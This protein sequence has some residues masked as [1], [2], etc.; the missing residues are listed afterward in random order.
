MGARNLR[1]AD[2]RT[3]SIGFA[4]V[5]VSNPFFS[6]ILRGLEEV[7]RQH[8]YLVLS[9]SSDGDPARQDQLIETFIARRVD[10]LVVVP[11]SEELGPISSEI[12]RGMPVVFVDCEPNAHLS[13]LVR[14]DHLGGTVAITE[15]LIAHGHRR[16]AFLGDDPR[17]FSAT[18]RLEGFRKAVASAGLVTPDEWVLTGHFTPNEWCGRICEWMESLQERP[19]A[20][21]AAQNFVTIGAVQA[22]RRLGAHRETALV[23]FDDFTLSDAVEPAITVMPQQPY[24][25]GRC[26]GDL[27]FRRLAGSTEPPHRRILYSD[28]IVRGSG[29]LPARHAQADIRTP[30]GSAQGSGVTR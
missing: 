27:L 23:G 19:T 13:D 7:A 8:D 10:G 25:L 4:M 3:A 16:L 18:L 11:S 30:D 9:G 15:H 28:I 1:R 5:D 26:A 6:S 24:E 14:S 12:L 29:E 22:L 17:I 20:I 2:P 21:V